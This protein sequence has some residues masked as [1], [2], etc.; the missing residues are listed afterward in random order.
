MIAICLCDNGF[1]FALSIVLMKHINL[2]YFDTY[3]SVCKMSVFL[4]YLFGFLSNW[5]IAFWFSFF[6]L[7]NVESC[8]QP[9]YIGT[10]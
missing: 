9:I 6:F 1:L 10:W 2:D 3:E 5:Y 7:F 4:N 8:V